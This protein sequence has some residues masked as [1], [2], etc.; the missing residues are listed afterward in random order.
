MQRRLA[1]S[2]EKEIK[3]TIKKMA[4]FSISTNQINEI[5][6]KNLK[7]YPFIF[8]N[9]VK[10]V[11]IEY[12]LTNHSKVDYDTNP[13][14]MEIVYKFDKPITE[15]FKIKYDLTIDE[16]QDNTNIEKRFEI[17]EKSIY[18]LFWNGIPIEV[19]FNGNNV[20][21]SK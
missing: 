10:S 3:D 6:E 15:N 11:K 16:S 14:T 1:L 4:Q 9:G 18:N 12:D 2:D 19:S 17:L 13:K 5:Q 7:M 21:K 8:F 20:Y